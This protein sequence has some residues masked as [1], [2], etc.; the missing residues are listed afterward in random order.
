MRIGAVIAIVG[1]HGAR[2]AAPRLTIPVSDRNCR[3]RI[4]A[5]A[6]AVTQ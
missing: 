5:P 1:A 2:N 3:A 4:L 6:A